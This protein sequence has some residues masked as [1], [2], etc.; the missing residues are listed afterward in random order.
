M[1]VSCRRLLI[2]ALVASTS[3]AGATALAQSTPSTIAHPAQ[4]PVAASPAAIT[5][6][7]T[8]AFITQL[9]A[10]MS[11]EEKVGQTIQGDIAS[12]T[13]AD[14]EKYPLG[15]ILA[16][17]NSA[18]GGDDRAPPK[19]WIDL[20]DAYRKEALAKRAG[21]TPIP[22]M[23]GIDAV[24]GHNN[25]VGATIFPHNIGL[26]AMR[27]P[28]LIRR[29][30]QATAEEVAVVGG[31]WTFGPTVAVP[32]DDRWGRSYEGYAED[33]E[34]VKS[35]SG[36]MTLG[37][38]GELKPGQTLGAGHI[39][40]SA[41][42]FLAD[43][44]TDGGQDQGDAK[45][46]ESE[47]VAIHAQGYPPSIDAGILTVMASFSS[48][49]G[50]KITGNKTLLTD[51]LKGRMGFQGFVVSDWNA[52]GQLAG[53]TNTSCPQAMNAGLDM[54][55]APDSWKGLYDNT[56]A[57][58]KAGEIPMARLDD[59]VRRI[60]RV[61]VKTG[62]FERV[63]PSVQGKLDRL[64]ADDH[65]AIAR[66]AVAKSL[67]LLKND[68]VLPVKPGA[69]VLVAGAADDIGKASGGWTL[70]W[71]GTGNKNS[72][73][74]HG[75]SIWGG[76][77]QAVTASGGQAELA[78]DGAFKTKP[79][80]AIVV[81]GEDPYAE[82]QGDVA[83]LGYQLGDKTDL[84]LLRKLKAQGIPVVSVFL[85]GRP[86][87]VNPEINASD[88]FVAA[89]LPG[90]EGGGVADVLVAGRDGKSK[91]DFQGKLGFSWPKRADQGPLNRG[92]PGYDPQFAYG[93]GLSYAKGAKVGALPEDPGNAAAAGSVDRYFVDGR[94]PAPWRMDFLGAGSVKAIDA[95]AQENAR[96]ADWTGQGML[97]IHG[98]AV[99]LSRQTTGDMAVMVRYRIDTAPTAPVTMS[100]G[101]SD[102]ASCGG[103]LD[104]STLLKAVKPGEWRSVKIKLSCFQ[105]AGAKMDHVT[106][107]FAVSTGGPF[108]LS[109]TEVRLA[110]NE[111]D[112]IC[113]K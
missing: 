33:P 58:V 10:R 65:R 45:I 13:P 69:R 108:S 39:A 92:Q 102:D 24:H 97:A 5:D 86:L 74:P 44:G 21:H 47:L 14:L 31:D 82:F 35:Y 77:E 110:S 19:A 3:L 107:P 71:Q 53:C 37:L 68:G 75:Q 99:D 9:M 18:P 34:V 87:W 112:A 80:V 25:I 26:G 83:N 109:L 79:D 113:P 98:P 57:Q 38:Q 78:P 1:T 49:N 15:S 103:T 85:S 32:R 66:E 8:E 61:K 41:K 48:W 73:F 60:L 28:A 59:A 22:I 20:V 72:D 94:L 40:G 36:P 95:G 11:V 84:A 70:T 76:I 2:S 4:W 89:W 46:P 30:G 63:A 12:M 81:F 100:I 51:V 56:L 101:C 67:V 88:A 17:G 104:V 27:D 55:M 62:L 54:Y 42:H 29:I 50:Q 93:Y 6:A 91:R 96:Q 64:G 16:G 106:A 90:S 7:K 43:G 23:F 52:H 105:A 111:G